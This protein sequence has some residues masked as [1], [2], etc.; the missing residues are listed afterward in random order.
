MLDDDQAVTSLF[1]NSHKLEG[2]ETSSD[3]QFGESTMEPAKYAYVM[4]VIRKQLN[5]S[6]Y[7]MSLSSYFRLSRI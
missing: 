6:W 5:P 3:F 4:P 1:E 2:G 7:K